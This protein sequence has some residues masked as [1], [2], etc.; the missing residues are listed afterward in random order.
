M[1]K[2]EPVAFINNLE[3]GTDTSNLNSLGAEVTAMKIAIGLIFQKMPDTHRDAFL[4]ELR[5]L[6]N[7]WLNRLANQLEQFKI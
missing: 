2:Q 6:D 5:Q 7:P 4:L 1:S 3:I